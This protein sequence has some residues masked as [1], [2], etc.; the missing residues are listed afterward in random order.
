MPGTIIAAAR[1]DRPAMMI[2]GGT[3]KPGSSKNQE[4]LD[5]VSAFQSYGWSIFFLNFLFLSVCLL[6]MAPTS[7]QAV[8]VSVFFGIISSFFF[9]RKS[10]RCFFCFYRGRGL[11]HGAESKKTSNACED[12]DCE[13]LS[14]FLKLRILINA[15]G[16]NDF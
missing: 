2:Y 6:S 1:L 4:P 15:R 8:G 3:I 14:T 16:Q 10:E 5:I 9:P 12:G 11:P 7:S 13:A